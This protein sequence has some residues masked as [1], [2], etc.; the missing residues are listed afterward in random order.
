MVVF[1]VYGAYFFWLSSLDDYLESAL[2]WLRTVIF[3]QVVND[4]DVVPVATTFAYEFCLKINAISLFPTHYSF[5]YHILVLFPPHM[6]STRILMSDPFQ[7]IALIKQTLISHQRG[8]RQQLMLFAVFVNILIKV[9]KGFSIVVVNV[10]YIE[11]I[12]IFFVV[13]I[14]A[15]VIRL[16]IEILVLILW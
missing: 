3:L 8:L 9:R 4:A 16:V 11:V 12:V 1:W 7:T 5:L 2:D 14:V 10:H 6:Q 15:K 13:Y